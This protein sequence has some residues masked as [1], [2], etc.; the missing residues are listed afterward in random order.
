MVLAD[1]VS[2]LADVV[3]IC[4]FYTNKC[5]SLHSYFFDFGGH[6]L[7][8]NDVILARTWNSNDHELMQ[9]FQVLVL[10]YTYEL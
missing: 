10:K 7:L 3:S 8:E 9:T 6:K 2:H 5:Y 1:R 4:T